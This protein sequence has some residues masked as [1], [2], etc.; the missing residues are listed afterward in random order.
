MMNISKNTVPSLTYTLKNDSGDVLDQA[1]K[2][3]PFF[4]LHGHSGVIAGLEKAL[5][6]KTTGDTLNL[7]IPPED[8]Y[9]QRRESSIQE[10]PLDMFGNID[11][12]EV[13]EGAQF[14]AETNQGMQIVTIKQVNEKTVTIDGNHPMAGLTLHFDI[15]I[16]EIRAATEEEITHGHIHAH[17]GSCGHNH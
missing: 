1:N 15:E 3:N 6:G 13:Y 5:E 7:E 2:E 12:S 14:Q 9:G 16:Q 4:Y 8:A 10:M 11:K 17:G